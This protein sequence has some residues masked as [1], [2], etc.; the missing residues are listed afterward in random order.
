MLGAPRGKFKMAVSVTDF[1]IRC[2]HKEQK[3]P[4]P[5]LHLPQK[6]EPTC[7]SVLRAKHAQE[8]ENCNTNTKKRI[9]M[10]WTEFRKLNPETSRCTH[11]EILPDQNKGYKEEQDLVVLHCTAKPHKGNQ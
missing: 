7:W 10:Y 6:G 11:E 8:M 4:T 2:T 1:G 3:T 5:P 9:I